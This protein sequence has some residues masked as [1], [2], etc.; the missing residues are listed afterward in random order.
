MKKL[1]VLIC[2]LAA[3]TGSIAQDFENGKSYLSAG[4]GL[5]FLGHREIGFSVL[6]TSKRSSIGP[7]QLSYERGVTEILGV[8]RIGVGGTITQAFYTQQYTSGVDEITYSRARLGL[9]VRG[10]YH[11]EFDIPK[12]DVYAGI[13]TGV[14]VN[15]DKNKVPEGLVPG[16]Y[17]TSRATHLSGAHSL[18]VGIRYYF[19][20]VLGVYAET[21][22]GP[23]I[24]NGGLVVRL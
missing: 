11:F 21:G 9:M 17:I 18:F 12:M 24:F 3:I 14:Y 2:C 23:A 10:A 13:G 4:L 8:G 6:G 22:Y 1:I 7:I 19:T 15:F 16:E 20:D 5:D